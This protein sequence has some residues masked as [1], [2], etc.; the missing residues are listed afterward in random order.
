MDSHVSEA[1]EAR[2]KGI[3]VSVPKVQRQPKHGQR[4]QALA[5]RGPWHWFERRATEGIQATSRYFRVG[6]T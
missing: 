1:S 3:E 6:D 4:Y 5:L 2:S